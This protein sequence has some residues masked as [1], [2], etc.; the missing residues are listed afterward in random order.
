MRAF[1]PQT[2]KIV[3]TCILRQDGKVLLLRNSQLADDMTSLTDTG[4]FD[5]PRFVV[6][7]GEDPSELIMRQFA[8][9][10]GRC[11]TDAV[12]RGVRQGLVA[13]DTVHE[14]EIVYQVI[15]THDPSD[16]LEK[17]GVYFFAE[18][19]HVHEYL[20]QDRYQALKG[21]LDV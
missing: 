19:E 21:Y 3:A 4:Y 10:F 2:Q 18:T 5:L 8:A 9:Y 14:F 12:V 6:G 20:L 15:C 16:P 17:E 7:F 1:L 11:V 13:G